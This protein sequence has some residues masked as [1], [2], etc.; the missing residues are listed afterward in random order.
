MGAGGRS[1]YAGCILVQG[2][3]SLGLE[4][5][6][7]GFLVLVPLAV[8]RSLLAFGSRVEQGGFPYA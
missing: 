5:N 6:F 7:R 1:A 2:I 3:G 8:E 4:A